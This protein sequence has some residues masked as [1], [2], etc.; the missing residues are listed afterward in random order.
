ML[1][2]KSDFFYLVKLC[3]C[4]EQ[5]LFVQTKTS[6]SIKLLLYKRELLPSKLETNT[7]VRELIMCWSCLSDE[8]IPS[9]GRVAETS[10]HHHG[11]PV[12]C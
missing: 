9:G 6:K 1:S 11:R 8:S 10:R 7:F 5:V 3:S 2:S 4:D 12:Y